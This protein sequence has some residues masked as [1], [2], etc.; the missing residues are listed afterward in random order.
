MFSLQKTKSYSTGRILTSVKKNIYIK[1]EKKSHLHP[2]TLWNQLKYFTVW[3][4][5]SSIARC[6]TVVTTNFRNFSPSQGTVD[7]MIEISWEA[8]RVLHSVCSVTLNR[9]NWLLGHVLPLSV[10]LSKV[11]TFHSPFL[12]VTAWLRLRYADVISFPGSLSCVPQRIAKFA[13]F[14]SRSCPFTTAFMLT[15]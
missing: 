12:T 14:Y 8:Q 6:Q 7:G 2:D 10:N 5:W 11:V 4:D 3:L 13:G 9:L 15:E 1:K